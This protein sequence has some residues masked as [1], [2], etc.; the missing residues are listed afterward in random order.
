[1]YATI[2]AVETFVDHH[3]QQQIDYLNQH[4]GS[5]ELLSLLKRCQLDECHHRDE[6]ALLAGAPAPWALR[7]WCALVGFG[8]A[9]AVNIA[10]RF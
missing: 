7:L 9:T 2:A 10:R 3:Y 6:A 5:A 8:S 4:G 1:V